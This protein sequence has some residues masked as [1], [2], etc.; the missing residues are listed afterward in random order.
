MREVSK[1]NLRVLKMKTRNSLPSYRLLCAT[2]FL[3]YVLFSQ[4]GG[5]SAKDGK[6]I[7]YPTSCRGTNFNISRDCHKKI[8]TYHPSPWED[9]WMLSIP[10]IAVDN[11]LAWETGCAKV[12]RDKAKGMSL[13]SMIQNRAQGKLTADADISILSYHEVLDTCTE[14]IGRVYIEPLVSFLRHPLAHCVE[15][16]GFKK[17][18]VL[19]KSYLLVPSASEVRFAHTTNWLFDIGSGVYSTADPSGHG[20]REGSSQA[21]FV[22]TF[23]DRGI[24]FDRILAWE[25][26]EM[27][28]SL[29]WTSIPDDVKRIT[30]W[31]NI[32]VQSE[33][34][35]SD[36]P[37]SFIKN[38]VA[39]QDYVV[40]KLDIDTP[41]VEIPLVQQLLSDPVLLELVDEFFFEHHTNGNPMQHMGWGDLT[42]SEE[43]LS[44]ITDSYTLFSEL[45]HRGVRAHS[46]I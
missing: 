24:I 36:N 5:R 42:Q 35:H 28:P 41:G 2:L 25:A 11:S 44:S 12:R 37:W 13:I 1:G 4:L 3:A 32:P 19:D 26:E 18:G 30:S 46:W 20:A 8:L 27:K 15:P 16:D 17:N 7:E 21:W 38:L 45:R 10:S 29:Q 33:K 43:E 14:V 6:V 23:R 39:E 34:G 31:Y 22:E 9:E 40:V